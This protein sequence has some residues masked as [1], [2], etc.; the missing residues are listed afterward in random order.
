[1]AL[2]KNSRHGFKVGVEEDDWYLPRGGFSS[3]VGVGW[4]RRNSG[5][6]RRQIGGAMIR[7]LGWVYW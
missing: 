7:V 3:W 5:G 4:V 6:P 1:M 2:K